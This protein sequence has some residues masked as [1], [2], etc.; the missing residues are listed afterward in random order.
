[1]RLL[2][3]VDLQ[4]QSYECGTRAPSELL[5]LH[6]RRL[7]PLDRDDIKA[8]AN[9]ISRAVRTSRESSCGV[10][11]CFPKCSPK[12]FSRGRVS[13]QAEPWLTAASPP[14]REVRISAV[15]A[16]P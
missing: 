2:A 8:V 6:I 14:F 12:H 16:L 13:I 7:A 10:G 15:G 3:R 9:Y 1:M 4:R 5:A 11:Q